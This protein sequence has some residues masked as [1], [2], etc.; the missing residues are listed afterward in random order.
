MDGT[1]AKCETVSERG[2]GKK[3]TRSG[4]YDPFIRLGFILAPE[5]QRLNWRFSTALEIYIKINIKSTW[6]IFPL[7]TSRFLI[8]NDWLFS[9]WG[10]PL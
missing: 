8:P 2:G 5:R 4:N 3:S 1:N 9:Q 7:P 10:I 6:A